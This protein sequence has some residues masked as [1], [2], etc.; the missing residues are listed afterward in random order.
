MDLLTQVVLMFALLFFKHFVLD[1]PLQFPYNYKNKGKYGHPG[2]LAHAGAHTLGSFLILIPV[3]GATGPLYVLCLIEGI[4][5]YHVDW[6]KMNINKISGWTPANS[7]QF[8][9]LLGFDQ[10]LHYLTY[11][12][13]VLVYF[14]YFV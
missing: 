9:W 1:F 7:E 11:A 2:G 3:L 10:L 13:M 8:W 14:R 6:A 5:H 4:I 12:A